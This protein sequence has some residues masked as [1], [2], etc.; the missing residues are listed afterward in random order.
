MKVFNHHI[1]EYRKGLRNLILHTVSGEYRHRIEAK[2]KKMGVAYKIYPLGNGN[3][4]VFFGAKECVDI[5]KAIGKPALI[6]YTP[7]EDFIL[8]TMLG[9]GRLQ[10][11]RRYIKFISNENRTPFEESGDMSAQT[12]IKGIGCTFVRSKTAGKEYAQSTV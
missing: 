3:I 6:D 8:G 12:G 4:N 9:Y 5:I 10:Q 11:C 2:L 1:Y 7:E